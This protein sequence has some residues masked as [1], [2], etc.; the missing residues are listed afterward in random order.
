MIAVKAQV[1][2]G[3]GGSEAIYHLL[4]FTHHSYLGA[5]CPQELINNYF[6]TMHIRT[7]SIL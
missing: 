3:F 7:I 6:E 2:S 4:F 1:M 5:V